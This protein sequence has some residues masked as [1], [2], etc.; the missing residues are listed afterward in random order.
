MP[1][2]LGQAVTSQGIARRG[3]HA[4]TCSTTDV[5]DAD[6]GVPIRV[7]LKQWDE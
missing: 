1:L 5:G 3:S 4:K 6:T 7:K 2:C